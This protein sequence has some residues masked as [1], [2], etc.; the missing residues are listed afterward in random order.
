M[1]TACHRSHPCD[2]AGSSTMITVKQA[3][4]AVWRTG[5]VNASKTTRWKT[6]NDAWGAYLLEEAAS[7]RLGARFGDVPLALFDAVPNVRRSDSAD[8]DREVDGG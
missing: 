4:E 6:R 7:V 3:M 2:L 5:V 8:T 1:G